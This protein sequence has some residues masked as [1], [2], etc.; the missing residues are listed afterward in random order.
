MKISVTEIKSEFSKYM[1]LH[2]QNV[3]QLNLQYFMIISSKML[4]SFIKQNSILRIHS[5]PDRKQLE[6]SVYNDQF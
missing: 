2:S 6:H 5:K 1:H 4:K 3:K